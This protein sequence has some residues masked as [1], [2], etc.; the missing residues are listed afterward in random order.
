LEVLNP[1][2]IASPVLLIACHAWFHEQIGGAFKIATELAEYLARQGH[3]VCYVCGTR[4]RAPVNPTIDGGVEL[5]RYP[6]P[7]Q[8]SP[9]PAN[10]LGHVRGA[11]RL[12]R[13]ILR[14]SPVVCLNGHSPLQFLGASLAAAGRCRRQVYSVHSPFPDELDS[15]RQGTAR[16]LKQRAGAWAARAIERMNCR[17]ATTVQCFSEFTARRL[18]E[19]YGRAVRGKVLVSPGWVDIDR[20]QPVV[21]RAAVR[22]GLGSAWQTP[23]PLFLTVRRLEARMGLE[24][25]I[26]AARIL[27]DQRLEFRLLIGGAGSLEPRLRQ[28]VDEHCLHETVCVLGRIPDDQLPLCFAAADCFVLPTRVLE[29]F[30]LIILEAYACGI[31]VIGTPVGAIPELVA[32]QGREWLTAGVESRDLAERMAAFLSGGLTADRKSLRLYAEQWRSQR[33]LESLAR[34][35]LPL[36]E[37]QTAYEQ[38]CCDAG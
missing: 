22:S 4:E 31:P 10:L 27:C 35:L 5:W 12:T 28:M 30:G 37:T 9:H 38:G 24:A 34:M 6:Y 14:R 2:N 16:S 17:R 26:E 33:G 7:E 29:C 25:L 20:F 23:K 8:P 21:D 3:H 15:N 19:L 18:A 36:S 11:Y 32:P 1:N 13:E